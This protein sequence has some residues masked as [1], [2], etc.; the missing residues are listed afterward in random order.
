MA[1]GSADLVSWLTAQI[2]ED[3]RIANAYLTDETLPWRDEDWAEI[4]SPSID[5]VQRHDPHR[6]LAECAAKRAI[7]DEHRIQRLADN[8][9]ALDYDGHDPAPCQTL[10]HLVV[11][12]FE[13]KIFR[14]F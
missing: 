5:H 12:Q 6:V 7:I 1:D 9:R 14:V 3:D 13:S 2:A 10:R 4:G 8:S 11:G